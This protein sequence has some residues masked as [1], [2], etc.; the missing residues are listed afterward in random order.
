[1]D[2]LAWH[3]YRL[4]RDRAVAS[5]SVAVDKVREPPLVFPTAG[6]SPFARSREHAYELDEST[7]NFA[8]LDGFDRFLSAMPVPLVGIPWYQLE[9]FPEAVFIGHEVGHLVEED[10]SLEEPLRA[11]IDVALAEAPKER[12]TAW[13]RHWRSEVFADVYGVLVC[14]SAYAD[15]LLDVLADDP[16][17]VEAERQPRDGRFGPYPTR[18][19][20]ALVVSTATS[21]LACAAPD[22]DCSTNPANTMQQAW[23]QVYPRHAMTEYEP[24]VRKVVG[25]VMQTR[26]VAFA[27]AKL[28]DGAPLT[29]VITFDARMEEAARRDAA[30]AIRRENPKSAD[31]RTLFAGVARAFLEDSGKFLAM[32]VQPRFRLQLEARRERGPRRIEVDGFNPAADKARGRAA[33][34]AVFRMLP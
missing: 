29:D 23:R 8:D 10:L 21:L 5:G 19:L 32:Q 12:R 4:P 13:S 28:P 25:S 3:A 9:H 7:G 16:Q 6:W 20:R 15:V 31:V 24:D 11:A 17:V 34:A 2:E 26:L 22:D 1:M 30:G 27:T 18:M 14:G 33:A